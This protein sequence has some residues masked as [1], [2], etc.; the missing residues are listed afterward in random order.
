MKRK[1]IFS[2][3]SQNKH[4]ESFRGEIVR[5]GEDLLQKLKQICQRNDFRYYFHTNGT[6]MSRGGLLEP[7]LATIDEWILNDPTEIQTLSVKIEGREYSEFGNVG[8]NLLERS[9]SHDESKCYLNPN[10]QS[11]FIT[12][13]GTGYSA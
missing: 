10:N 1:I 11:Q 5:A 8:I 3:Y 12:R 4:L 7:C 2:E 9:I 13:F 6:D